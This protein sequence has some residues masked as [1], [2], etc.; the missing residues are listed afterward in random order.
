M[1]GLGKSEK[2][3]SGELA[4]CRW[5][6]GRESRRL[7]GAKWVVDGSLERNSLGRESVVPRNSLGGD[8]VSPKPACELLFLQGRVPCLLAFSEGCRS[9]ACSGHGI[10]VLCEL[11]SLGSALLACL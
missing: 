4:V 1:D 8:H 7:P 5:Q 10:N 11:L 9:L 3:S 2:Q 6:R